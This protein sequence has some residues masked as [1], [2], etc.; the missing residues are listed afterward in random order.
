MFSKSNHIDDQWS[1]QLEFIEQQ[2]DPSIIEARNARFEENCVKVILNTIDRPDLQDDL[3]T[4]YHDLTG[5]VSPS[6]RFTFDIFHRVFPE[7]PMRLTA[8]RMY[9]LAPPD[10]LFSN[11]IKNFAGS[12]IVREFLTA[13]EQMPDVPTGVVIP[14][15]RSGIPHGLVIH[16]GARFWRPGTGST[17]L[18]HA[19][20]TA[21]KQYLLFVE[22]FQGLVEEICRNHLGIDEEGAWNRDSVLRLRNKSPARLLAC[23]NRLTGSTAQGTLLYYLHRAQV[24]HSATYPGKRAADQE[25][26]VTKTYHQLSLETGI[27]MSTVKR[28]I[29]ALRQAGA[30][31]TKCGRGE[32]GKA[33]SMCLMYRSLRAP[34]RE[35]LRGM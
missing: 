23:F 30:I 2:E 6:P 33:L 34:M 12:P 15:P 3:L 21:R 5:E 17:K 24:R 29:K 35:I 28:A 14:F 7:F 13:R 19:G 16:D 25:L 4:V 22:P 9:W 27:P 8:R 26:W 18:V 31:Q 11:L 20:G 10:K 32:Q 1:E